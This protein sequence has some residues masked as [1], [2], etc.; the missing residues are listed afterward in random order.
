VFSANLAVRAWGGVFA[1]L[2][3]SA[4][5][6]PAAA[7][8]ACICDSAS[9][10]PNYLNPIRDLPL[11]LS[12]PIRR[13][14]EDVTPPRLERVS[15]GM[16]VAT[17]L[18]RAEQGPWLMTVDEF[19]EPNTEYRLVADR[20]GAQFTTGTVVDKDPPIL[21]G[22]SSTPGGNGGLCEQSVGAQLKLEGASDGA[23]F[24]VWVELEIDMNGTSHSISTWYQNGRISLG[25]SSMGCF[26]GNELPELEGG[27]G[28]PSRIRLHDA[29]GNVSDWQTFI[30]DVVAEQPGGCG[31]PT[32]TA[33]ASSVGGGA[34]ASTSGTGATTAVAGNTSTPEDE[35]ATRTSK[36]CGCALGQR[37][38]K[39][40]A[41]AALL[42]CV[43][44]AGARR[45][46]L[47][48]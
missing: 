30:L 34:T 29:G 22:V 47:P 40:F 39:S 43:L 19:L 38:S 31:T 6:R 46:R 16:V 17:T 7:C 36:G 1:L 12:I 14:D 2:A 24:A 25:H 41:G 20:D 42:A 28:Y 3:L 5:S 27:V 26:G 18:G 48:I 11:N 15:D 8:G 32:T 9:D 23:S 33:G 4:W 35:D 10:A 44:A 37:Q 21:Q 45:R 13:S